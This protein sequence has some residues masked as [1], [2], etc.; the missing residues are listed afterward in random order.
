[1][2]GGKKMKKIGKT[3]STSKVLT[4]LLDEWNAQ[5]KE[6]SYAEEF[7]DLDGRREAAVAQHAISCVIDKLGL[8]EG[9]DYI[10]ELKWDETGDGEPFAYWERK[11]I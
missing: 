9:I 11:A 6:Q 10:G 5:Q 3:M 8:K 7:N 1:M 4:A 2:I